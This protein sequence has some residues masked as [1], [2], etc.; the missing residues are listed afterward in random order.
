[1]QKKTLIVT[2]EYPPQ[3]GGIAT[4]VHELANALDPANTIVLAPPM[5]ESE[6]WDKSQ[7]YT[8]VRRPLL[9][10]RFIWPRWL[11]AMREVLAEVKKEKIELVMIHH[12]LPIGYAARAALKR[13]KTPFLL[14]SH[15]TDMIAGT[16]NA[17]KKNR[18]AGI[19]AKA[20]QVILNSES[21]KRRFL[22][23][24]PQFESKALV[25]YPCPEAALKTPPPEDELNKLRAQYGLEGKKVL[26]SVSRLD[27]GKGFPHAVRLMSDIL[28]NSPH[29]VWFIAGDGPKRNELISLI[30]K[31]S[32]QN[33]V[34]YIGLVPHKDIKPFYYLADLFMLLTHPDEG[35][36][37]GLGLVFL[38][39]QAVG[40]PVVAGKSGGVEEAVVHGQT[41]L[42]YDVRTEGTKIIKA[43]S[44]LL[45]ND[46]ARKQM[47]ARGK[48]R[49]DAEFN[50][51]RQ[52]GKISKWTAKP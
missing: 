31:K 21:L 13:R 25:L 11:K 23:E 47:G 52:I 48:E 6:E 16:K 3:V 46:D 27:E 15:G 14:F 7:K 24:F 2:L 38:E 42:V 50:W 33:V 28:K 9:Y 26:L 4:F 40:L 32:L 29:L 12:V 17:W 37:E 1:M 8:V 41:G 34:R 45:N 19:A 10:P 35:R 51:P 5:K 43:V 22:R 44:D 49:I 30:Q 18:V 36:E 39:A 20:E